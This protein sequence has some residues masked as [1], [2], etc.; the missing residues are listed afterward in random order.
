MDELLTDLSGEAVLARLEA[1]VDEVI[2]LS[3]TSSSD[4][5]VVALWQR[6]EAV[7][8]R[9]AVADHVVIAEVSTRRLDFGHGC[10]GIAGFARQALRI[11]IREAHARVRARMPPG[12]GGR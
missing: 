10:N 8:R 9:L 11:G 3:L 1:A 6:L 12:R 7:S 4:D 2:G 5:E